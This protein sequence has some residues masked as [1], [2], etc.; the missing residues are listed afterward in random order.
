[1]WCQWSRAAAQVEHSLVMEKLGCAGGEVC[2]DGTGMVSGSGSEWHWQ[3]V[4]SQAQP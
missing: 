4:C 1:M 3:G 2:G